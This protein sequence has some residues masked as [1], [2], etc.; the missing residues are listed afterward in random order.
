MAFTLFFPSQYEETKTLLLIL[1]REWILCAC[2]PNGSVAAQ[3]RLFILRRENP[4][5]YQNFHT[6]N[7]LSGCADNALSSLGATALGAEYAADMLESTNLGNRQRSRFQHFAEHQ[8]KPGKPYAGN[9]RNGALQQRLGA[10]ASRRVLTLM[11]GNRKSFASRFG[12]K[13][14]SYSKLHRT[15]FTV[16]EQRLVT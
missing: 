7:T 1:R 3:Q 14:V 16:I 9:R 4:A 13:F 12:G 8:I 2:P 5:F 11:A 15:F 6:S 10:G